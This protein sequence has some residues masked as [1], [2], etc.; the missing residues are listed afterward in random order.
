[1]N[2]W[3][4]ISLLIF[5]TSTVAQDFRKDF[6][7]MNRYYTTKKDFSV[8]VDIKI[9]NHQT[10]T[11]PSNSFVLKYLSSGPNVY[12]SYLNR[13]Y[14]KNSD[15]IML[16]D[17]GNKYIILKKNTNAVASPPVSS[18]DA[19]S[20]LTALDSSM[21]YITNIQFALTNEGKQYTMSLKGYF[22][23]TMV[24]TMD[25]TT[26]KIKS[27]HYFYDTDE[28]KENNKVY[29]TYK[30]TPFNENGLIPL[31]NF[32][33]KNGNKWAL[34]PSYNTYNLKIYEDE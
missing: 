13:E 23:K 31:S 20:I 11:T 9:F 32:V 28:F 14:I 4:F 6:L 34:T 17:H 25:V 5:S 29:I 21:R 22:I 18:F 24:L 12:Y 27:V 8:N 2:F 15:Q 7:E 33:V 1:M 10:A 19:M 30:E 16:V 26:F 3:T